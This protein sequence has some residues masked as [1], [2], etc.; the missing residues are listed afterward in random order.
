MPLLVNLFLYFFSASAL[1][2]GGWLLVQ[3]WRQLAG[4]ARS[5]RLKALIPGSAI[6]TFGL[7]IGLFV[8]LQDAFGWSYRRTRALTDLLMIPLIVLFLAFL[9]MIWQA[10]REKG[11]QES[12]D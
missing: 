9:S 1:L 3:G 2:Y 11:E 4:S 12:D 7:M 8:L 5:D 6:V 10:N